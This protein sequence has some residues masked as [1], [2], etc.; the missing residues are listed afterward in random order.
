MIKFG[1]KNTALK[2]YYFRP[3]DTGLASDRT[4]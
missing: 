2:P 1:F 3:A 4:G